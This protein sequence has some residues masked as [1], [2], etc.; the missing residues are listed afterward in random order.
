MDIILIHHGIK[1]QHWGVRRYENADGTLTA[2]GKKRYEEDSNGNYIKISRKESK[3]RKYE[4]RYRDKG[5][6]ADTARKEA[7]KTVARNRNIKIAVGVGAVAA[8]AIIAK[9][10]YDRNVDKTYNGLIYQHL[11]TKDDISGKKALYVSDNNRDKKRYSIYAKQMSQGPFGVN[12]GNVDIYKHEFK[13]DNIKIAGHKSGQ[14][15]F[16][17]MF[18]SMSEDEQNDTINYLRDFGVKGNKIID[19]KGNVSKNAYEAFNR[20]LVDHGSEK[21]VIRTDKFYDTLKKRGFDGI[22]DINDEKYSGYNTKAK[23]IFN[24]AKLVE[25]TVTKGDY[26]KDYANTANVELGKAMFE[27]NAKQLAPVLGIAAGISAVSSIQS[28]NI[29]K[30]NLASKQKQ[31]AIRKYKSEHPDTKMSN[32]GIFEMLNK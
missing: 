27:R 29:R 26:A 18:K 21:Q 15:A 2:A 4:Q 1:G 31:A 32:N 13:G 12:K 20:A 23:I 11:A 28:D 10:Y 8:G 7:E 9:K 3:I 30:E 25:S 5:M 16:N 19:R 22:Q 14:K 24:K 17:D 6:N